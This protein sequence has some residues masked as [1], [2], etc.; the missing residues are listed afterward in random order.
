MRRRDTRQ[1]G[2]FRRGN[3]EFGAYAWDIAADLFRM[4]ATLCRY[5]G[6][7]ASLGVKGISIRDL[8]VA[9]HPDDRVGFRG[10]IEASARSGSAFVYGFRSLTND[11]R[12]IR[13]RAI[14]QSFAA[15]SNSPGICTGLVCRVMAVPREADA[16][17]LDHCI[18]A[19]ESAKSSNSAL[20][21]YLISMVLI[22]IGYRVSE[23]ANRETTQV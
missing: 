2:I 12:T 18:A 9:M 6:F 1:L 17:L 22:E 13:L 20:V 4:D 23:A 10:S 3:S 5:L 11:G 21:Q 7:D 19:Y 15:S 16:D 14:G 8:A